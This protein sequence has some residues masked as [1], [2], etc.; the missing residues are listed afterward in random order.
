MAVRVRFDPL[1]CRA[2]LLAT[3]LALVALGA[4]CG[5]EEKTGGSITIAQS[6]QPD[7]LDPALSN[8]L[9]GWEP[10]WL[11]YTPPLTYRRPQGRAR[12]HAN[13]GL[14]AALPPIPP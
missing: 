6:A 10:M 7:F 4:G 2:T 11:V 14:A 3:V 8:T 12:N 13:P 5:D 1:Q 9:N